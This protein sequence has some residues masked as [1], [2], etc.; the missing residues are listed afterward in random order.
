MRLLLIDLALF[1]A[2]FVLF[3]LYAR[4]ANRRRAVAG[5]D[6]LRTPWFWLIVA[7]LVL[8]IAGFFVLRAVMNQHTG[9]YVPAQMGPDGK[10]IPAHYEGDD[11]APPYVPPPQTP[12]PE[13]PPPPV[14]PPPGRP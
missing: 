13:P 11:D 12:P 9:Q 2:P 10:L 5:S 8:A 3:F 1:A 7:A 4:Y 14:P 6:P